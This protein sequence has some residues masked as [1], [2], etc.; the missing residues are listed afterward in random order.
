MQPHKMFLV[1]IVLLAEA[2]TA[3]AQPAALAAGN[4]ATREAVKNPDGPTMTLTSPAFADG[5]AIPV[6]YTRAGEGMSPPLAWANPPPGTK[7]FLLH[8]HDLDTPQVYKKSSPTRLHWLVWN[9]PETALG[10]PEGTG[11]GSP[12]PAGSFQV[13]DHGPGYFGPG[14]D[15]NQFPPDP[16]TRPPPVIDRYRFEIWAL[17]TKLDVQPEADAG[18]TRAKVLVAMNGHVLGRAVYTA[19]FQAP[20][21]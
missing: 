2:A 12:G 11:S 16:R 7:S 14:A 17:D 6:K 9:I 19:L 3:M 20:A 18:T 15:Q 13:S 4:P 10:M 1:S 21:N 5:A 8:V